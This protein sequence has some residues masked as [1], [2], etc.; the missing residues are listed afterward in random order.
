MRKLL[1]F[2]LAAMVICSLGSMV[3]SCK[4]DDIRDKLNP[5]EVTDPEGTLEINDRDLYLKD[6]HA[7]LYATYRSANGLYRPN[8]IMVTP[9][10]DVDKRIIDGDHAVFEFSVPGSYT[11]S[12]GGLSIPITVEN[13]D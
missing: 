6:G 11:V 7:K 3:V 2:L 10:E 9:G 5:M 12:A 4:K 13:W 8:E 1:S